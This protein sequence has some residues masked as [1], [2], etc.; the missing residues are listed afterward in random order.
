MSEHNPGE[1]DLGHDDD[2]EHNP[3]EPE[4]GNAGALGFD[5]PDAAEDLDLEDLDE[6]DDEDDDEV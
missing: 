2:A 5:D 4:F 1:P 6:I 3:G